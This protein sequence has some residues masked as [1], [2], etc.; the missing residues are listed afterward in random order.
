V[1]V[2]TRG[3]P[4]V[5]LATLLVLP[6]TPVGAAAPTFQ[7]EFGPCP[8]APATRANVVG[9]GTVSASLEGDK[10]RITGASINHLQRLPNL[11][12]GSPLHTYGTPSLSSTHSWHSGSCRMTTISQYEA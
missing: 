1:L 12:P 2:L 6:L 10:L 4:I 9:T 11:F 5:L 8:S 7:G 3:G